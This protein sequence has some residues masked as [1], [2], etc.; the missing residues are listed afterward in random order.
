MEWGEE[1]IEMFLGVDKS[2]GSL[3]KAPTPSTLVSTEVS[4]S[5]C[6][7]LGRDKRLREAAWG[8]RF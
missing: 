5:R 3:G 7:A 2:Q 4:F 8:A 1:E 6:V